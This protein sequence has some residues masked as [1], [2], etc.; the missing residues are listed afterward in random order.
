[1]FEKTICVFT[2]WGQ[3]LSLEW[4]G[5]LKFFGKLFLIIKYCCIFAL[6]NERC[7]GDE[8]VSEFN[9]LRLRVK[10]YRLSRG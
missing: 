1:M 5:D 2:V 6:Q 7:G 10:G 3:F 4:G 8:S 9:G